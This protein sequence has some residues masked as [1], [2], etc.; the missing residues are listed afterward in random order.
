MPKINLGAKLMTKINKYIKQLFGAL[1]PVASTVLLL[2]AV[3]SLA[4]DPLKTSYNVDYS[5]FD[6]TIGITTLAGINSEVRIQLYMFFNLLFIP[7]CLLAAMMICFFFVRNIKDKLDDPDIKEALSFLDAS[8]VCALFPALVFIVNKYTYINTDIKSD[9]LIFTIPLAISICTLFFLLLPATSFKIYRFGMIISLSLSFFVN[10]MLQTNTDNSLYRFYAIYIVISVLTQ[11]VLTVTHF[12]DFD[13]L[14]FAS[15]PISYA[16][17][18]AGLSLEAFNVL[19]RHNIFIINRLRAAKLVYIAFAVLS[20]LLFILS[21]KAFLKKLK[22]Y[23]HW[24][25]VSLMGIVL[26]F[27]YFGSIP[28]QTVSAGT[29]LFETANHGL[30]VDDFLNWG[31]F[32]VINSFDAHTLRY[33]LGGI[34][35]GLLND[36]VLGAAYFV[37]GFAWNMI[38]AAFSFVVFKNLFD[39]YFALFLAIFVP[40]YAVFPADMGFSVGVICIAA[41]LYA[42]RKKS[43]GSYLLMFFSI[44]LTLIY[45]IPSGF[46]YG[47]AVFVVA[48]IGIFADKFMDKKPLKE[49]S[50]PAFAK[51]FVVFAVIVAVAYVGICIQQHIDPIKRAVEFL[52]IAMSTNNWSR[53]DIGDYTTINY[54]IVYSFIPFASVI[55]IFWLITHFKN[56][57][58]W[59]GTLAVF[60]AYVLNI[61]RTLQRHTLSEGNSFHIIG[62][63]LLGISLFMATYCKKQKRLTFAASGMILLLG[64]FNVD[65]IQS[66]ASPAAGVIETITAP[67]NYYNGS[68]EK[69]ERVDMTAP[70]STYSNVI[71]MIN[72]VIPDGETYLDITGQTMLYALSGREKP[73]Y[74]NQSV[75]ELSG[76]YS[77]RRLIEEVEEEYNGVCDFALVDFNVWTMNIDDVSCFARYYIVLEYLYD[78]Y[79][80]LCTADNYT[81]WVRKERYE[82]FKSEDTSGEE[83][84]V[85]TIPLSQENTAYTVNDLKQESADPLKLVCGETDPYIVIPFETPVDFDKTGAVRYYAE[86]EYRS[87]TSGSLQMFYDFENFNEDDSSRINIVASEEYSSVRIPIFY[88]GNSPE[89][90]AI[91]LDPPSNAEFE[92]ASIKIISVPVQA[93]TVSLNPPIFRADTTDENWTNGVLNTDS[94]RM[95]FAREKSRLLLGAQTLYTVNGAADVTDIIANEDWIQI[96]TDKDASFFDNG[97]TAVLTTSDVYEYVDY[98][99]L[100][101]YHSIELGQ[102]PYVWGQFD[103]KKAWNNP[104]VHTDESSSGIL[105]QEETDIAKYAVISINSPNDGRAVLSFGNSSKQ[106]VTDFCF[107]LKAGTNRYII[108]C[109]AD[110]FWNWDIIGSF[111]VTSDTEAKILQ[112][113]FLKGDREDYEG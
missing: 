40:V 22:V 27:S 1:K 2:T 6:R 31:K 16:M 61:T 97:I 68:N 108:R 73:V 71:S 3:F 94:K 92:V 59:Y 19:N 26:A 100:G 4:F 20:V 41:M 5:K 65:S 21:N 10:F 112:V 64:L 77:Q 96:V 109:S 11:I 56:S 76:E 102:L 39:K 30:L 67:V 90:Y 44:L 54:G 33:S 43:F 32:P 38:I 78:T 52:S 79:R 70:L 81:L 113:S 37:Y 34:L 75:T 72:S 93:R 8:S 69:I 106:T 29:E 46:S 23:P 111:S 25:T 107:D 101:S 105:S 95:V 12:N 9:I 36:D 88:Y 45:N 82:E 58:L 66:A 7:L 48:L 51:A 98:D 35:Y 89:L 14:T 91:R 104:L 62:V 53:P 110:Y 47:G 13:R 49:T 87:N 83:T 85:F 17:L 57:P 86:I 55:C 74:A 50:L 18:F 84:T 80:P 15:V 99:Y 24:E 28:P 103:T 60:G 42:L 63:S